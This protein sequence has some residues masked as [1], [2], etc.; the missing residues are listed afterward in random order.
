M[1]VYTYQLINVKDVSSGMAR[2]D[3]EGKKYSSEAWNAL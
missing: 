2:Q 3:K 1:I